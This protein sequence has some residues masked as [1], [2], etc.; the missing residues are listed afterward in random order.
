M[1]KNYL[2]KFLFVGVLFVGFSNLAQGQTLESDSIALV[3]LYDQCGGENWGDGFSNWKT[4]KVE[5]W[6]NVTT[7]VFDA[8][9]GSG[10]IRRVTHIS[11]KDL[12]LSGTLPNELGG[13]T[14][15][16]GKIELNDQPGLTGQLPSFLWNWTK[17]ERFQ[18]K[19]SGFTSMDASGLEKMVNLYEFN[20]EGTKFC[21]SIPGVLF[22]LPAMKQLYLHESAFTGTIPPE[23]ATAV[24][25]IRLYLTNNKLTG[26]L[27]FISFSVPGD[28]KVKLTGNFFGFS[29][30][31]PYED[32]RSSYADFANDF[33]FAQEKVDIYVSAG[34]TANF[35]IS[36]DGSDHVSW[37]KENEIT[38]ISENN[39]FAI[40]NVAEANEGI[41]TCTITKDGISPFYLKAIFELI[42]GSPTAI[43]DPEESIFSVYPNPAKSDLFV[44]GGSKWERAFITDIAGQQIEAKYVENF[45]TMRIDISHL[46]RGGYFLT[47]YSK[48]QGNQTIKFVKN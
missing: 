10:A 33:Q 47:L 7:S 8:E 4:E 22:E 39:V 34:E 19:N 43:G 38:P 30:V 11:F 12:N 41:Y 21:G 18:V 13:L 5:N 2:I 45:G 16:S 26:P 44:K 17:V 23:A 31:Q 3:A 27:P 25:L 48:E 6:E 1:N 46:E 37:F 42:I 32:N 36:V 28:V 29:D 40:D 9:D 14:E 15:M 20:T 24:N 35:E